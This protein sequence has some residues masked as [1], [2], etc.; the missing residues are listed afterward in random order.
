MVDSKFVIAKSDT[1]PFDKHCVFAS[2]CLLVLEYI[3]WSYR[4][5]FK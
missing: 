1:G 2:D 5:L 4:T 3:E